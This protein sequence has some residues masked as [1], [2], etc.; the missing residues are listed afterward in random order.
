MDGS[1]FEKY[2]I[3]FVF[4]DAP[5]GYSCEAFPSEGM[6]PGVI[7]TVCRGGKFD[8][9]IPDEYLADDWAVARSIVDFI[10]ENPAIYA[11]DSPSPKDD[12]CY[13]CQGIPS[14]MF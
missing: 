5:S 3:G 1:P 13:V 9:A 2:G 4:V 7:I 10:F 11:H 14:F 12:I 8:N 6:R